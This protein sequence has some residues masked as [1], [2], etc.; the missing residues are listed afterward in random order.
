MAN[1]VETSQPRGLV[2]AFAL[3]FAVA[4]AAALSVDLVS[5]AYALSG[6]AFYLVYLFVVMRVVSAKGAALLAETKRAM[7]IVMAWAAAG[8]VVSIAGHRLL[9]GL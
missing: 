3:V 6:F 2:L 9:P 1:A 8:W 4:T 7:P 5:E